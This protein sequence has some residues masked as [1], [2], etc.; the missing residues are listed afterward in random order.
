LVL[1]LP[2]FVLD[3]GTSGL[4]H[5]HHCC[6]FFEYFPG[7]RLFLRTLKCCWIE[8]FWRTCWGCCEPCWVAAVVNY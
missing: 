8:V 7:S 2:L 5:Y 3:L 1:V 6:S 4:G